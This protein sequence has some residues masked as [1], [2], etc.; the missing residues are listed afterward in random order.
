MLTATLCILVSSSRSR[1]TVGKLKIDMCGIVRCV[2]K[3]EVTAVGRCFSRSTT[4][5]VLGALS[6]DSYCAKS[7]LEKVNWMKSIICINIAPL[8]QKIAVLALEQLKL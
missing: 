6:T 4:V 1:P 8:H 3:L 5:Y 2:A 7:E